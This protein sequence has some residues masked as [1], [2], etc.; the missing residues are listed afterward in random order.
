MRA[1]RLRRR[2]R[3][4]GHQNSIAG[5]F[6]PTR[7]PELIRPPRMAD[8]APLTTGQLPVEGSEDR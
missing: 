1:T 5:P 3:L 6:E 2:W 4:S 8:V 7:D